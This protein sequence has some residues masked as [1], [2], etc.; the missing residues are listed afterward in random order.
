V[1]LSLHAITIR[2][3]VAQV[4]EAIGFPRFFMVR[5]EH[6]G[7]LL[8][9]L[10]NFAWYP[11]RDGAWMLQKFLKNTEI[12]A[13]ACDASIAPIPNPGVVLE[14]S[15]RIATNHSRDKIT[16]FTSPGLRSWRLSSN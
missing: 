5:A 10:S 11:R 2:D 6:W 4:A 12:C 15:W 3:Q 13:E 1:G 7:A 8:R 14:R 9:P 16:I